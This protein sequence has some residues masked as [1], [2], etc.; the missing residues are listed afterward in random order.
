MV[1]HGPP[2]A[3]LQSNTDTPKPNDCAT[4]ERGAHMSVLTTDVEQDRAKRSA[5]VTANKGKGAPVS[6]TPICKRCNRV[7]IL[8][9]P[10]G[11]CRWC[12]KVSQ[13]VT[14]G[15]RGRS[16]QKR[17][18]KD[19]HDRP[20]GAGYDDLRQEGWIATEAGFE[21]H[22][23]NWSAYYKV[24]VRFAMK[25]VSG[26][27]DDLL[28]T[29]M[30]GLAAVHR[31]KLARRQDFTEAIMYRVAEHIKDWYWYKRYSYNN[32][33]DCRHCTREQQGKCKANWAWSEWAYTDCHRAIQLESLNQPITD[34]NGELSELSE[35]I[36]D[37]NALDLD[38]WLD[39]KVFLIGAPIRLKAIAMKKRDGET[40][41]GA[42]RKYLSKLRKRSQL[43]LAGGNVLPVSEL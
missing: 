7:W 38:E 29:I 14:R 31:R 15:R 37:D 27:K 4:S 39:A 33:L 11:P 19:Y 18:V 35:L 24:G 12:G 25:A 13:S 43:S 34:E 40:L 3:P 22:E 1:W 36:A 17:R 16:E 9:E 8:P 26:E 21:W 42:E 32:G 2:V 28:H 6:T 5:Q 20:I 10:T 23:I 41:T 30:E